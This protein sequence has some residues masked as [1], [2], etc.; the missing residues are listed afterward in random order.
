MSRCS[1]LTVSAVTDLMTTPI[2]ICD[3]QY[4]TLKMC[5]LS[6]SG[7]GCTLVTL[8]RKQRVLYLQ[9]KNKHFLLMPSDP[10]FTH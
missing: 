2:V 6:F 1:T 10:I 4:F 5:V 8:Q 9:L 7:H 3:G